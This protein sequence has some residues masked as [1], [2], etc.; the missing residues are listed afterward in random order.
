MPTRE[1]V[2]QAL[3][4]VIDPELRRDIVSLGM[5][6]EVQV[7][8]G[9]EVRVRVQLTTPACP[10][11]SIIQKNVEAAVRGVAG[12]TSVAVEMGAD[13]ASARGKQPDERLPG[14]RNILAVGSGKGGV[15]K[16]TVAVNLALALSR[17]G[18]RVGLMDADLYGPSVPI[19]L[20]LRDARAEGAVVDGREVILPL[21]AHGIKVF[22][23]GFLLGQNDA[24]IWRGPMLHKAIQQFL[25]DVQWGELDYLVVDLPPGT[26]DVQ[27]SLRHL[28]PVT[29]AVVVTTPQDVAFAD[30]QRAI[31]MFQVAKTPVL[32]V[33]ENMASFVCPNCGTE[34]A[35]FGKGR[36]AALAG[37]A[38]IPVLG[39]LPL[40]A[41]V[42]PRS[43]AGEPIVVARPEGTTATALSA[44]A[45]A[46]ASRLSIL[47][48]PRNPP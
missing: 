32:G 7:G 40:D 15:G 25:E 39:S 6:K 20:G 19:M 24:V 11:K 29:A 1:Q 22:S 36:I 5:V 18:A 4:S 38:G 12:V 28:V 3:S 23:M 17:A 9:G 43:D 35:L 10:L 45:S 14:V 30:V 46:V 41:E 47:S 26:G 8:T 34:H 42:S 37:A 13:V 27:L 48:I 16:S 2:I 31:R 44:L 21:E 33:V